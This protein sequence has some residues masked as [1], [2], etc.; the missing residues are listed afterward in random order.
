[1]RSGGDP[2]AF[3]DEKTLKEFLADWQIE[4]VPSSRDSAMLGGFQPGACSV[5]EGLPQR[6]GTALWRVSIG[7]TQTHS[8]ALSRLARV[9]QE[10]QPG[11]SEH[12]ETSPHPKAEID[13][14]VLHE[15]QRSF[16]ERRQAPARALGRY[17]FIRQVR[18]QRAEMARVERVYLPGFYFAC[19]GQQQQVV[20]RAS[21][22]AGRPRAVQ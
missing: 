12:I 10:P 11:R 22:S 3:K 8:Q 16:V 7:T 20:N 6:Q 13:G 9:R 18:S 5:E 14:Y 2:P 19:A 15:R 21:A 4:F 17:D 1:M